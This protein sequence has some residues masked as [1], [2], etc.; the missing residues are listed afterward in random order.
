MHLRHSECLRPLDG[1]GFG[2]V[3]AEARLDRISSV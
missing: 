1:C 2:T 3:S